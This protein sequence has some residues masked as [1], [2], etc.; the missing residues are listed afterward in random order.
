[1]WGEKTEG[2]SGTF[3][4]EKRLTPYEV[5]N[6]FEA[7]G[8]KGWTILGSEGRGG[9]LFEFK[10]SPSSKRKREGLSDYKRHPMGGFS[11]GP[12]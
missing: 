9:D 10:R 4:G 11:W 2:E 12:S 3:T 8:E 1:L 7:L 6:S 5:K